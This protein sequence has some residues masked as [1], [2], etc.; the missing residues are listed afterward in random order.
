MTK[1]TLEAMKI[2]REGT[3]FAESTPE[4]ARDT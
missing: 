1:L 2:K 4:I 3:I